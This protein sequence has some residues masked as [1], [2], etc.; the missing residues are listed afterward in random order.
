MLESCVE[1]DKAQDEGTIVNAYREGGNM[2]LPP[3]YT[4][5]LFNSASLPRSITSWF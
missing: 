5:W 3:L 2:Y 1:A 4:S